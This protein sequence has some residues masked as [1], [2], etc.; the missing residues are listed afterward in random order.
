M[1]RTTN[2]PLAHLVRIWRA[3]NVIER[4]IY[5]VT[6]SSLG[7]WLLGAVLDGLGWLDRPLIYQLATYPS[8]YLLSRQPWGLLTYMWL[9]HDVLHLATNMLMLYLVGRAF[10]R[11]YNPERFVALLLMGALAGALGYSLGYQLLVALDLYLP[12]LPMLGM[13]A[14]IYALV[15]GMVGDHPELKVQLW[16]LGQVRLV[17]LLIALMTL[18]ILWRGDN[19]GGL[20]AHL[21][22]TT[23]GLVWGY[24]FSTG[25][26]LTAPLLRLWRRCSTRLRDLGDS[27]RSTEAGRPPTEGIDDILHKI[28]HS[29]YTS[30]SEEERQRLYDHSQRLRR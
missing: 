9:H 30:L 8:G 7:V 16:G 23:M 15:W 27:R 25:H 18:E 5:I 10:V 29:G 19:I 22:G 24:R 11:S 13:S 12:A 14:G 21:G 2:A 20:L 1:G 26:D 3:A 17:W 4:L 6:L 28:K